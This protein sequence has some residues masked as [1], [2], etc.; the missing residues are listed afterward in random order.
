MLQAEL[1]Q[2]TKAYFQSPGSENADHAASRWA[3]AH[4]NFWGPWLP[5]SYVPS[6]APPRPHNPVPPN[7]PEEGF[8]LTKSGSTKCL[9]VEGLTRASHAVYGNCDGAIRNSETMHD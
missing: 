6:P 9:T 8:I 7:P 3:S 1:S 4:G 2:A 5:G